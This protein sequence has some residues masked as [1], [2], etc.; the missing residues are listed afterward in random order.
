MHGHSM[1]GHSMHGG[2]ETMEYKIEGH[3]ACLPNFKSFLN[4]KDGT[5]TEVYYI[6][7]DGALE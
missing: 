4:G 3:N 5:A 1:H 6:S 7:G 2:R